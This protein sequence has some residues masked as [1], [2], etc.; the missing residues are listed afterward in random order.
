MEK[1]TIINDKVIVFDPRVSSRIFNK[2]YFGSFQN[3]GLELSF[4]EAL[5]L[6][7]KK[8]L[9]IFDRKGKKLSRRALIDFAEKKQKRFWVRYCVFRSM[10]AAGFILKTAFK[11]GGDFRVYNKGDH[12]GKAH[13]TWI[14]YAATEHESIKF[15]TFSAV[16][17][18][19]HSVKKR[20]LFGVV[21]DEDSVTYYEINWVKI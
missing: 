5:Y 7:E 17:R 3:G 18:V 14:L 21:D 19:A 15:L 8:E 13:A 6:N 11:Y 9:E 2:G 16:N 20:V 10:R 4:E 12:P 1:T